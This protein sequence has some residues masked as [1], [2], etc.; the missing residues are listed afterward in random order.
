MKSV[1]SIVLSVFLLAAIFC[2]AIY[3]SCTQDACKTVSCLN[4]GTCGGGLC[5]CPTGW[6]GTLCQTNAFSG[7]WAG[8]DACDT[9]SY[10]FSIKIDP[11][12]S[13][14][15][16]FIINTPHGYPA[17]VI[18]IR[19]GA[20]TINIGNQLCDTVYLSGTLTLTSNAALT[21]TYTITD[22]NA[23]AHVTQCSGQYTR[24]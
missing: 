14:T 4:G 18:G 1:R 19:S 21:F 9:P 22:N 8:T 15:T 5:N 24:Q 12:S 3:M 13:D 2:S 7:S 17:Q 10:N 20:T 23:K 16:K 11:S 6:A